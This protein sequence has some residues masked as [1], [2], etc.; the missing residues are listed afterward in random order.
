MPHRSREIIEGYTLE[1]I[2]RS[3]ANQERCKKLL[4]ADYASH[5]P[6]SLIKVIDRMCHYLGEAAKE[7]YRLFNWETTN[8]EDNESFLLDLRDTDT[9]IRSLGADLRYA[10]NAKTQIVPWSVI[11]P[12]EKFIKDLLPGITIMLTS[13]WEYKYSIAA[14]DLRSQYYD[15]LEIYQNL[16]PNTSL[17]KEV[18]QDFKQP[19]HIISFPALERKNILLHCLIGHEI[20]HL[21]SKI[22]I[23]KDR[24]TQFD[25][26]IRDI[27]NGIVKSKYI[28]AGQ[29]PL[30]IQNQIK[31]ETELEIRRA[32]V[33]WQV[34]LAE[35]LSDIIGAVLFGPAMLFSFFEIAIQYDIDEKPHYKNS[36]YPP[37][38][39]RLREILRTIDTPDQEFFPLTKDNF[40]LGKIKIK[41]IES[42]NKRFE[43]I[44]EI[45]QNEKDKK[46]FQ[47]DQ[48]LKT[49]YK[50][51]DKNISEAKEIIYKD[52]E[53][54][55]IKPSVLYKRLPYLI[56]RINNKIPP[57]A[58]EDSISNSETA[59]IV[60]IINAVWFHKIS[61]EDKI[62]NDD[63]SFNKDICKDRDRMNRLTLKAIE[64]A[65][66]QKEFRDSIMKQT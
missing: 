52:L 40:E 24:I 57:N 66:V 29:N 58:Y 35:I 39:L 65:D 15:D 33:A 22:Y 44:K 23:N 42:V 7:I 10:E 53:R 51:I 31:K 13:A 64:Y 30:F 50:E 41:S 20:G 47:D 26:K 45:T 48:I 16:L 3:Q 11:K 28:F 59:T 34:G 49:V 37:C 17:E 62:F 5:S 63:G 4:S 12:I 8:Y 43:L 61:W 54:K 60:E 1:I 19:F 32:S 6:V 2:S 21:F 27:V 36:F 38:R 14:T 55:V 25:D 9:I 56:D 46:K 18:F